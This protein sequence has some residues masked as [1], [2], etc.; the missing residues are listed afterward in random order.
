MTFMQYRGSTNLYLAEIGQLSLL[1]YEQEVEHA[2]LIAAGSL[3][4]RDSLIQSNLWLVVRIAHD[5]KGFGL[6][7]SDLIS[8]GNIGLMKAADKYDPA[9][10][11]KFSS[12]SSWW[13]RQS[14]KRAL[15]NGARNIRVP[16]QTANKIR[17]IE[18]ARD[19]LE[20]HLAKGANLC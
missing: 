17:K 19:S 11:A 12:Y 5:F 1:T 15:N 10:G 18:A 8:E 4:A 9:K 7:L 13:I 14:M 6:P 3:E 2:A 20:K 16:I